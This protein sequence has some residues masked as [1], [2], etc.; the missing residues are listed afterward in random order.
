[1]ARLLGINQQNYNPFSSKGFDTFFYYMTW[2]SLGFYDF[3]RQ[4]PMLVSKHEKRVI[5]LCS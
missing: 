4:F 3:L 5:N 2:F 1:M